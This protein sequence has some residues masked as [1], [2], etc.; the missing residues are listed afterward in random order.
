VL[1]VDGLRICYGA[2]VAVQKV[3]LTVEKGELVAVTGRSGAGKTTLLNALAGLVP[4]NSGSATLHGQQLLNVGEPEATLI[5]RRM[6]FVFQSA[7][8][9]PELSVLENVIWVGRL[10]GLS[11]GESRTAAL[12]RLSAL[13]VDHLVSR[14]PGQISGGEAQR[15]NI[16][17]ALVGNVDLLLVDEPTA[18]LDESTSKDVCVALASVVRDAEVASLV[19]SHDPIVAMYASRVVQMSRGEILDDQG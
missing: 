11:R 7:T 16:A 8:L 15:V 2:H 6:G 18:A 13:D 19:V 4:V 9:F 12:A 10:R 17:R 1:I 5:R 3:D 14:F